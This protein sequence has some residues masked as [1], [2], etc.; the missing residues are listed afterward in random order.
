MEEI[1]L[2]FAENMAD[3]ITGPMKLRLVMQPLMAAIFAI[4]SGLADAKTGKPPYFWALLTV[5]AHRSEM[6]KD[7]W[8]SVGKVFVIAMILDVVYQLI[9]LRFVYPGEAIATAILLAIV[10]YL[11]LRGLTTRIARPWLAQ[12][13]KGEI[14]KS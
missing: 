1:L 5:P 14:K 3:R 10:P 6:L 2:R 7:G 9:A 11:L 8:K 13:S 4:R 12:P